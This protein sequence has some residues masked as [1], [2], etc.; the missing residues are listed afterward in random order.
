MEIPVNQTDEIGLYQNQNY[1]VCCEI[2][3][4]RS[5][6]IAVTTVV[7]TATVPKLIQADVL[8][9]PWK[10]PAKQ[11]V[12]RLRFKGVSE[13]S[14]QNSGGFPFYIKIRE[15][16]FIVWFGVIDRPVVHFSLAASRTS[17]GELGISS[18][19]N[20]DLSWYSPGPSQLSRWWRMMSRT[21]WLMPWPWNVQAGTLSTNT[22]QRTR[23][24]C[25]FERHEHTIPEK[26]ENAVL[27]TCYGAGQT[28][29][30]THLNLI[31]RRLTSVERKISDAVRNEPFHVCVTNSVEKK[32]N[33][34][35]GVIM[36][37]GG[38]TVAR[39]MTFHK[40]WGQ[41]EPST[42]YAYTSAK[43]TKLNWSTNLRR[44]GRT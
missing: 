37:W 20:E 7:S 43:R 18:Q 4:K 28:C 44:L 17:I 40:E 24:S 42:L 8:L 16:I 21:K 41:K 2:G 27:D 15:N 35:Q 1:K 36:D 22:S 23:T 29:V 25:Q 32:M 19:W 30:D 31:R 5:D 39:L 38:H 10:K 13:K 33:L 9:L 3:L 34:A 11:I 6:T 26:S 12:K 14:L